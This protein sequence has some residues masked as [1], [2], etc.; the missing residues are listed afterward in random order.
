MHR[1]WSSITA[2]SC[3]LQGLKPRYRAGKRLV[4]PGGV[5]QTVT[6]VCFFLSSPSAVR[7]SGHPLLAVVPDALRK[8]DGGLHRQLGEGRARS[9]A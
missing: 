2:A 6:V 7:H 9:S 4:L 3:G 1:V 8:E 5:D